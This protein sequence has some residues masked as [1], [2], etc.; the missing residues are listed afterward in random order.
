[1]S[2]G[3]AVHHLVRSGGPSSIGI[4]KAKTL[5]PSY[6]SHIMVGGKGGKGLIQDVKADREK[7]RLIPHRPLQKKAICL[8]YG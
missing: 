5:C 3:Q 1:M 4:W 7:E 8:P 2:L 6:Q